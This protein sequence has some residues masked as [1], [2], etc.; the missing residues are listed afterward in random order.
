VNKN[1][2]NPMIRPSYLQKGDTVAIVS[3]AKKITPQEIQFAIQFLKSFGLK[4]VLGKNIYNSWNRFSGTDLE[5]ATDF[6]WALDSNEVKAIFC[7]R[8]GYGSVC[9]VDQIDFDVFNANPK[10]IIGYSDITVFHNHINSN[11]STMTLHGPMP[12]NI[13][14]KIEELDSAN[15]LIQMLFGKKQK[16]NFTYHPLNKLGKTSGKLI[17]GNLSV[18]SC[19]IGTNSDFEPSNSILFL[20]DLCEENYKLD[21]MLFHLQK[22][23]K[24]NNIKGVLIGGFTEMT[25]LSN[26]F[27]ED[28]YE[29][30]AKRFYDF[31]IP[32]AFGFPAGHMSTNT[33]LLIGA[34][35][36]L[37]VEKSNSKLELL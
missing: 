20:E 6:Q 1:I 34:T 27:F 25:D 16:T 29:L 2:L 24:F 23:Q 22:S 15:K 18:L 31:P 37:T 11:H 35:Y 10:W 17:G 13:I 7:S 36:S 8:G 9:I 33:P 19:L 12:L 28:S 3:P 30:I 5:R 14:N 4:V 21:R 32:I 26:W